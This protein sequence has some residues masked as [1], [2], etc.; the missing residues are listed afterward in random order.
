MFRRFSRLHL[1]SL[2]I[3]A[4]ASCAAPQ[5]AVYVPQ[6]MAGGAEL[7]VKPP[8]IAVTKPEKPVPAATSPAPAQANEPIP[9][10]KK[11]NFFAKLF[12]PKPKESAQPAPSST[13][14]ISPTPSSNSAT[15]PSE[16][17]SAAV[18]PAVAETPLTT[19]KEG[20]F[21]RL[22]RPKK[23]LDLADVEALPDKK[24]SAAETEKPPTPLAQRER[25]PLRNLFSPLGNP[26]PKPAP[27]PLQNDRLRLP[28]MLTMPGE[29]D[30]RNPGGSDAESGSV[31]VKPPKR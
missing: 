26:E 21:A 18:Q 9:A 25:S 20:F 8:A 6:A 30:F 24:L 22:F 3:L 17:A 1:A 5:K 29:Q 10:P 2:L 16:Q 7:W 11:E 15:A 23:R 27:R 14:A 31:I 13:P 12:A 4:V 19:K 28:D